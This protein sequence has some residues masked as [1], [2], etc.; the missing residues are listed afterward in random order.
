[1]MHEI[2]LAIGV[3]AFVVYA[4]FSIAH[5]IELRRASIALRQFIARTEENLH[6][7]L[8][9]V[10]VI[11]ED[12]RETADDVAGL[13]KS[14]RE[15]ADT[16][17]RIEQGVQGLYEYYLEGMGE[18]ARANMAGLKAGVKA[19]MITLLKDLSEK[20]EGSS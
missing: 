12:I 19:G 5:I 11:L 1:M 15:A 13:A 18:T 2:L 6:P 17:K 10:R 3:V 9:A 8:A 16:A 20:K 7:S 14:V 4:A